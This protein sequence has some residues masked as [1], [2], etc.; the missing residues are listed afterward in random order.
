MPGGDVR[1][2]GGEAPGLLALPL[3]PFTKV[4]WKNLSE[5][6][7]EAGK[8]VLLWDNWFVFVFWAPSISWL[9]VF[10]FGCSS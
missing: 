2:C 9:I 10:L 7:I 1:V 5:A 6:L 3:C 4:G 8:D